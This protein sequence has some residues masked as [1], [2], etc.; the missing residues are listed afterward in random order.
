MPKRT[1]MTLDD[2]VAAKLD[3]ASRKSGAP[4]RRVLNEA[5]RRG[6]AD[7]PQRSKTKRLKIRPRD[8]G[9]RAGM[10]LDNI[11]ELLDQVEGPRRK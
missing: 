7:P 11:S 5:L 9:T 2:D 3:Q 6:L 10:N 4:F 1:T 8:L